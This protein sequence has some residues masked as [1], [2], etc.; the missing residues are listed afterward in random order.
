MSDTAHISDLSDGPVLR[1]LRGLSL[2]LAVIGGLG[3]VTIMVL[4]NADVIG[5]GA[6]G[7]PVPA[8]AEI[9]SAAIVTVVFLQLPYATITGRNVRSDII[10]GR[11]ERGSPRVGYFFDS[12]HHAVGTFMLLVLLWYIAPDVASAIEDRET[13]GLYRIFTMPR[14][15]FVVAVLIG[16]ALTALNYALLT[17]LLAREGLRTPPNTGA[18]Q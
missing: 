17:V 8:T 14:W 12:F 18:G 2:W 10:L 11:I 16:C 3:T 13:V 6:F 4:I 7:V 1:L 15:P 9:V 5:R